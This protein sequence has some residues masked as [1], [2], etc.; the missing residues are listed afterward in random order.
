M[1]NAFEKG[2]LAGIVLSFGASAG[3]WL[4]GNHPDASTAR[5]VAVLLQAILGLGIG[6]V[7]ILRDRSRRAKAAAT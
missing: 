5:T 3:N 2:V 1:N 4:L 7:L 6:V